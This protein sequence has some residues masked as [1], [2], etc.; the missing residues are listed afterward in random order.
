MERRYYATYKNF[1]KCPSSNDT[2]VFIILLQLEGIGLFMEGLTEVLDR[3][4]QRDPRRHVA[5]S[6]ID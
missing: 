1:S 6:D 5:R 3:V 4:L 2:N